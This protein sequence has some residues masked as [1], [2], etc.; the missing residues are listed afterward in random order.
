MPPNVEAALLRVC[1]ESLTNVNRHAY[2]ESVWVGLRFEGARLLLSI[3][4][5]GV[6]FDTQAVAGNGGLGL[7]GMRERLASLGG[8]LSISSQPGE[9]TI[10]EAGMPLN[11]Y[12]T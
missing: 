2:A 11:R 7:P 3:K 12:E 8:E 9:G 4:D 10:I 1:Q 6:G 5:N